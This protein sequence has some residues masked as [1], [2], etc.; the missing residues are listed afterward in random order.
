MEQL[1]YSVRENVEDKNE[2]FWL[3]NLIT[4]AIVYSINSDEFQ[5]GYSVG[6]CSSKSGEQKH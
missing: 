1:H 4:V 3:A 6:W 2:T 5:G